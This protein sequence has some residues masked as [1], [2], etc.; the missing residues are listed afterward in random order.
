[1]A[2]PEKTTQATA[3]KCPKCNNVGDVVTEQPTE[4]PKIKGIVYQCN[5]KLCEWYNS[6]WI[7]TVDEDGFVPTR[8]IGHTPKRFQLPPITPG[9]RE[10]IKKTIER[11]DDTPN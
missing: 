10:Q 1:M 6:R 2:E 7:I 8:D 4:N 5:Y 11:I 9:Q 3:S